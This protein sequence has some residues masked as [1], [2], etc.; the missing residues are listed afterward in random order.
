MNGKTRTQKVI[1]ETAGYR[2]TGEVTLP[3]EGSHSRLS[4][5]L[6][7][8]GLNFIPLANAE[9]TSRD[10]EQTERMPFI[11]VARDSVQIAYEDNRL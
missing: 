6:N 9:V 5:L 8:E 10:N 4:D 11:G 2:I 3:A 1:L 7:R